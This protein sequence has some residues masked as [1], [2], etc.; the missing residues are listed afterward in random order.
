MAS[1]PRVTPT[2]LRAYI[3]VARHGSVKDAAQELAVTEA[4]VSGHVAALRN[5]LGDPLFTR[6]TMGIA[7]TPGGLRLASRAAEMLGL[8]DQTIR[9]VGEAGR[10]RR[11][12]RVASSSL[13]SE[14]CAPGLI[15]LFT[16]RASDLDIELSVRSTDV[17]AALLASRAVDVAIGPRTPVNSDDLAR[18]PFLKYQMV[19]VSGPASAF[20]GV[21]A[22]PEALRD[23]LWLLGPSATEAHSLTRR[24]VE[25]IGV[26]ESNQ[27]IFQ[28][29]AAAVEEIKRSRGIGL[30]VTFAAHDDLTEGRLVRVDVRGGQQEGIWI[31]STLPPHSITSTAAELMRF[32]TTPR[33]TQAMLQGEG[34]T[35]GHFKPSVHVTLWS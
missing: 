17:A 28:S 14:Y 23:E 33:A 22:R 13:F 7:F 18:T 20:A 11:L 35:I 15:Q 32:I 4:A 6:A 10:G 31:A 5:E 30:A 9:E 1:F 34:A 25:A 24:M 16:D 26:P 27:R 8:R 3:A 29:H 2:Q 12:L 21:R 19:I